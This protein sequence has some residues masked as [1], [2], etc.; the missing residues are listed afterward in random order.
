[1]LFSG[2]LG[3]KSANVGEIERRLRS[4]EQ[5]LGRSRTSAMAAETTDHVGDAVVSALATIANRVLG[6]ANSANILGGAK[7][8]S[9]EAGK[10]TGGAARLGNDVV[11]RVAREIKHHPLVALAVA[12]GVGALVGVVGRR[13]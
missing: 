2:Y 9:D 5:S 8:M 13:R 7:S 12:L 11:R 6:G 3:A 4:I 1:M 10:I